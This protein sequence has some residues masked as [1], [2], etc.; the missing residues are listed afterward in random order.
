MSSSQ[1]CPP[2]F[3][4]GAL[5][6]DGG[7]RAS[8]GPVAAQHQ[9]VG[10]SNIADRSRCALDGDKR[11][12]RAFVACEVGEAQHLGHTD[13]QVVNLRHR[14]RLAPIA[15]GHPLKQIDQLRHRGRIRLAHFSRQGV[16]DSLDPLVIG[17]PTRQIFRG[18]HLFEPR[19]QS[20][21]KPVRPEALVLHPPEAAAGGGPVGIDAAA[22]AG[23]RVRGG[24]VE[25]RDRQHLGIGSVP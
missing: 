25:F 4:G 19:A 17:R 24:L 9:A 11:L 23:D 3:A 14:V 18:W 22:L 15:L 10:P 13:V 20:G 1:P 2:L 12:D 16:A 5:V 8:V 21:A 6:F 7:V